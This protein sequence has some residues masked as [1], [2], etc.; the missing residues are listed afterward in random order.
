MSSKLK[1]PSKLDVRGKACGC[2]SGRA[3]LGRLLRKD[4]PGLEVQRPLQ[5]AGC[6]HHRNDRFIHEFSSVLASEE[7]DLQLY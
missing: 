2:R 3:L 4:R 5:A 6:D 1:R 7:R